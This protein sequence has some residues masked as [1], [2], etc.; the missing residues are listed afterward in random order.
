[1]TDLSLRSTRFFRLLRRVRRPWTRFAERKALGRYTALAQDLLAGLR[2]DGQ[3]DFTGATPRITRAVRTRSDVIV[4]VIGDTAAGDRAM[5]LKLPL[6]AAAEQSTAAHRKVVLTL[7]QAPDLDRFCALIPRSLAWGEHQGQ[8]YYLETALPGTAAGDLVRA[9]AEPATLLPEAVRTI[10]QLHCVTAE[11]QVVD[12]AVF[13]RMAGEELGTLRRLAPHWPDAPLLMSRLDQ[14][15][16][17]LQAGLIGRE[18]PFAWSHGDYWP[19]NILVC[20]ASGALSGIVDWDRASPQQLPL[21]DILH[22][23]AYSR[24]MRRRTELGE[25]IVSYLLPE[26]F[27]PQERA[28]LDETLERLGLPRDSGFYRAAALLY[29]LQFAATN[30]SRYPSFQRDHIW[31]RNNVFHVLK[32]GL[33]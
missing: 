20:H 21:L 10:R 5:V 29:W 13:G 22:L 17:Q 12:A 14:L 1:M 15:E 28:L 32:R 25:E 4:L 24:K 11:R 19:G 8:T 9:R 33:S 7:H 31:M 27:A 6:T 23:L 18:L 26:A 30:L 16:A 3:I 2:N